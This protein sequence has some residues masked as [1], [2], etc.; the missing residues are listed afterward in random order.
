MSSGAVSSPP[1]SEHV[2]LMA[3]Y[4]YGLDPRELAVEDCGG[5]DLLDS[6]LIAGITYRLG[7]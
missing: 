1:L 3:S 5:S 6:S 7:G 4:R 2:R